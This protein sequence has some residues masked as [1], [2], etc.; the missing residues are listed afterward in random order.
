MK[1]TLVL[2]IIR[3]SLS[4]IKFILKINP[5]FRNILADT[6]R[7][8]INL[9]L[10]LVEKNNLPSENNLEIKY[11]HIE[12]K[13]LNNFEELS[14]LFNCNHSNRGII[15]LDFDEAA[16]LFHLIR[17]DNNINTLLEIGRFLGGST[18]LISVAKKSQALFTSVDLKVKFP[19]YAD[20]LYIEKTLKKIKAE[21]VFLEI[22]N[23][24]M[25]ESK[26]NLD[27][28]FI[29]G[30]HSYEGV[31]LDYLNIKK[32][33]NNGAHV[34]FHDAVKSRNFA[35]MDERVNQFINDLDSDN[36]LIFIKDI[37]SIRHFKYYKK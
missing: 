12:D 32:Y 13:K 33:L 24:R 14:F 18:V 25:Y 26:S 29:D 8:N 5:E 31:K 9:L 16:Y 34:L 10:W 37:G 19:K 6:L 11:N 3:I 36:E 23:S 1:R 20:D 2:L 22:A 17:N 21:N 4:P 27:F 35:T 7:S 30:D 15:A 28:C